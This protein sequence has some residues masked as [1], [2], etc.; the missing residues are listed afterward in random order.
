[1]KIISTNIFDVKIIEPK[2]YLDERGYF[3]ES[4]NQKKFD[5]LVTK[6]PT[7][8]VQD[9]HSSSKPGVFRGLHY[10][11]QNPQGKLVR[12]IAGEVYDVALDIREDSL[13]Y[14]RWVGAYLSAENK[15][16]MWIPPGFAHGFYVTSKSD[17]E[18]L[19]KCTNY[20]NPKDEV[21]ISLNDKRFD[22]SSLNKEK[23][24]ETF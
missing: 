24:F 8:F 23:I 4:W 21:E 1:M 14:G 20:Y 10:Q 7:H 18:F 15:R 13:T 12:V 16:Q 19:F 9:N 6:Q 3:T 17:A 2:Y 5:S 22:I 11:K